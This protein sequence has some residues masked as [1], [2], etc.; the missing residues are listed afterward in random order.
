MLRPAD[1]GWFASF[2]AL[3]GPPGSA[4]PYNNDAFRFWGATFDPSGLYRF[5][6]AMDWLASTGTTIADVHRHSQSLQRQFLDG[7][8]R[9]PLAALPVSAL[10]PPQGVA[11][12]NFLTFELDRAES[13]HQR[14]KAAGVY[15]DRRDRRI[16]FG[17][18]VYHDT[19]AVDSLLRVLRE[20]LDQGGSQMAADNPT[21]MSAERGKA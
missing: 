5:N 20:T 8:E 2:E 17:F 18:G 3:S 1:T 19:A 16:R 6:A 11:R 14:I 12:G 4:V 21:Q 9:Q 7:L 10:V 13:V 15:I